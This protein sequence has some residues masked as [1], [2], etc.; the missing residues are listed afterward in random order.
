MF[1]YFSIYQVQLISNQINRQ[2]TRT[3][4]WYLIGKNGL[5]KELGQYKS[6]FSNVSYLAGCVNQTA[7]P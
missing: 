2:L 5:Y 1:Y 7:A 3:E 4:R 6:H